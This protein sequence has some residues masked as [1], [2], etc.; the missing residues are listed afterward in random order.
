M[1]WPRGAPTQRAVAGA[2]GVQSDPV[3]HR[4]AR[5][6]APR[7]RAPP[8]ASGS[9]RSSSVMI[10]ATPVERRLG[11]EELAVR[12]RRM[13]A[14]RRAGRDVAERPRSWR[15]IRAPSPITRWSVTPTWPGQDDVVADV[16]AAGDPDA[17]HEEAALADAHVV[18]DVHQV[19]ELG[20]AADHGVVDA[21]AVDAGVGADLHLVLQDAAADVGNPLVPAG[22]GEVAEPGAADHRARLDDAPGCRSGVPG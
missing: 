19:V 7:H 3:Q 4:G 6:R 18:P 21:A 12:A 17:G 15:A 8:A 20:P 5:Q 16:R 1:P 11:A 14:E 10:G 2:A 9:S 22:A 13:A